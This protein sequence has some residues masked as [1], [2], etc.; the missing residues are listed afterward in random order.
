MLFEEGKALHQKS[1]AYTRGSRT[2]LNKPPL[3]VAACNF[4][5]RSE[6][7]SVMGI[8]GE[9]LHT[10]LIEFGLLTSSGVIGSLLVYGYQNW[11]KKK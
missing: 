5:A 2:D 10:G 6:G 3:V 7:K 9:L 11:I 8:S 1:E 4:G